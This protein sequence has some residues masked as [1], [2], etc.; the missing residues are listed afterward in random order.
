MDL[1]MDNAKY[2]RDLLAIM[3]LSVAYGLSP[4][5]ERAALQSGLAGAWPR[6]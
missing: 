4:A 1:E 6:A 2:L 3:R 5:Q